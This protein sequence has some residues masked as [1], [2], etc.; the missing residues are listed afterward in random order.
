MEHDPNTDLDGIPFTSEKARE[1][2]HNSFGVVSEHSDCCGATIH[3]ADYARQPSDYG[4][5]IDH[6]KPKYEGGKDDL[7][8]LRPLHYK[9]NLAKGKTYPGPWKCGKKG[10]GLIGLGYPPDTCTEEIA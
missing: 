3:F 10:I 5:H 2:W 7:P 9:N 1:V 6:I 4:W 8:N